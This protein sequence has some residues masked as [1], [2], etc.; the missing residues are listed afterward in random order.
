VS[1]SH[2][3]KVSVATQ[4]LMLAGGASSLCPKRLTVVQLFCNTRLA[5]RF[6]TML[7]IQE[8]FFIN[9]YMALHITQMDMSDMLMSMFCKSLNLTSAS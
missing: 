1:A 2:L 7:E 5:V 4:V 9:I 6:S 3:S 8:Y